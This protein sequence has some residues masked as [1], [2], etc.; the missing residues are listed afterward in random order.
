MELYVCLIK[1]YVE[2]DMCVNL[3][4]CLGI[5]NLQTW[6]VKKLNYKVNGVCCF[7]WIVYVNTNNNATFYDMSS[8]FSCK[9]YYSYLEIKYC[10]H[11]LNEQF[12]CVSVFIFFS[13]ASYYQ[14]VYLQIT[15]AVLQFGYKSY[16]MVV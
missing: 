12:I 2:L 8:F 15:L 10:C 7:R 16:N 9:V 11:F 1:R 13:V 4:D 14:L 3:K 6:C 5:L